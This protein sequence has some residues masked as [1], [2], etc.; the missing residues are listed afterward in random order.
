MSD[1]INRSSLEMPCEC[2]GE[3]GSGELDVDDAWSASGIMTTTSPACA[4][5][6]MGTW[7]I[8]PGS[9][10]GQSSTMSRCE[11]GMTFSAPFVTE[12]W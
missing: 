10:S 9:V 7:S 12:P 2:V 11:T 5:R 6:V 4:S 1:Q 8:R 3:Q